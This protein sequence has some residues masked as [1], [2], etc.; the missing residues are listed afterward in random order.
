MENTLHSTK[1]PK[2]ILSPSFLFYSYI[3]KVFE[4]LCHLEHDVKCFLI[5]FFLFFYVFILTVNIMILLFFVSLLKMYSGMFY[6]FFSFFKKRVI[7]I[8]SECRILFLIQMWNNILN[9]LEAAVTKVMYPFTINSSNYSSNYFFI[10]HGRISLLVPHFIVHVVFLKK[11]L[12]TYHRY[13]YFSKVQ[14]SFY[15]FILYLNS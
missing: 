4:Q 1:I 12:R 2:Y 11:F 6:D 3:V 10:N 9:L 7:H 13:K 15:F 8:L 14:A 5:F